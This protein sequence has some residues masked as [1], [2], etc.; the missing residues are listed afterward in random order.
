[1]RSHFLTSL[2][3]LIGFVLF[4]GC[5]PTPQIT[6]TKSQTVPST[7]TIRL[8]N[9]G[10]KGDS[11]QI[12]ERSFAVNIEGGIE[13]QAGVEYL[14][15]SVSGKY[16][17]YRNYSK[18]LKVIAP[19]GTN[20]EF[21][22][23][24]TALEW[25][26]TLTAN[27]QSGTYNVRAP[28]E[29]EQVSSRDKDDC[30]TSTSPSAAGQPPAQ[31]PAQPPTPQPPMPELGLCPDTV[32][33]S[34]VS[35]WSIGDTNKDNVQPYLDAFE[36]QRKKGGGF[37]KGDTIP[38]GVIIAEDFGNGESEAWRAYSVKPIIHYRSWGLFEVTGSFS[39]PSAGSCITIIP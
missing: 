3:A 2:L 15:G 12:T 5:T 16:D 6:E 25:T 7:E 4:S 17:Q 34:T 38:L 24:W 37:V 13:I 26:G 39:A 1:M 23:K 33:R 22:I 27:G 9:C 28:I 30:N 11:E 18:S 21:E 8:N 14:R 19:P 10:G 29:V 31:Q 35:E 32:A 20:M 36:S